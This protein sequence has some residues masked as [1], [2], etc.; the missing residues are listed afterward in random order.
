MS[1]EP[2]EVILDTEV[3]RRDPSRRKGPFRALT[4]LSKTGNIRIHIPEIAVREFLTDQQSKLR[5]AIDKTKNSLN[6]LSKYPIP[7]ELRESL[8]NSFGFL[9]QTESETFQAI[10][11]SFDQWCTNSNVSIEIVKN[12][13]ARKMFDAY[14]TGSPPFKRIKNREDIPDAFIWSSVCELC[15]IT[16]KLALC[17]WS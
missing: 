9:S 13:H 1:D 3:L 14:F 16:S 8:K 12:D 10:K 4:R 11:H 2:I 7:Q 5:S 15:Q 17:R 6:E